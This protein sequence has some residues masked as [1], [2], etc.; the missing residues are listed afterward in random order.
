[1]FDNRNQSRPS[2]ATLVADR[3]LRQ[4]GLLRDAM[5]I[6]TGSWIV[7]ACAQI[8]IP[9]W[10]VPVTGQTFGVLL[11]GAMLGRKRGAAA[12]AGYLLQGS[13]GLPFFA[14]G[15][16][17]FHHLAGP[18]GGYL[19]GFIAAAWITGLLFE[20]GWGRSFG[21]ACGVMALATAAIFVAGLA[22]LAAFVPMEG[23]L[24]AGLFP[25]IPGGILK[26]AAAAAVAVGTGK[27]AGAN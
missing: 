5:L 26:I 9:L 12:M 13:I 8:E 25:F 10:P 4:S 6:L 23:V 21:P 7:A 27:V 15:A 2:T 24:Q 14:G 16:S 20:R 11:I 19:I 1:M 18:T 22:W 17:G 3:L